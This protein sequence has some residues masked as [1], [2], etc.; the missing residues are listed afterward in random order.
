MKPRMRSALRR[1]T[2][3]NGHDRNVAAR[4]LPDIERLEGA[5]SDEQD[6]QAD[7]RR[8]T[9]RLMKMSVKFIAAQG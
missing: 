9:G 1:H 8:K 2:R 4:I 7:D 5:E 6:Q 3:W